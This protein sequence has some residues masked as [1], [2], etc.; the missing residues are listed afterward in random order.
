VNTWAAIDYET[1][2]AGTTPGQE[3]AYLNAAF[4]RIFPSGL[5]PALYEGYGNGLPSAEL[6]SALTCKA[7][8]KSV[9]NVAPVAKR[10]YAL[11]QER[12]NVSLCGHLF[13]ISHAH[14]DA[15]GGQVWAGYL[16]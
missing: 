5:E 11:T 15:L 8:W 10:G 16:E 3:T 14:V 6:Y 9:S 7:Y 2:S 4:G 1:P 12:P 13:D